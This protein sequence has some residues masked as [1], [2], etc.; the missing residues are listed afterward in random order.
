MKA[1]EA[2]SDLLSLGQPVIE[3]KEAA[4]RLGISSNRAAKLLRSTERAGLARQIRRGLWSLQSRI[5]PA[6]LALYLTAPYPAY[7]SVW[8]ALARHGIS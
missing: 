1:T 6:V 7:V 8:S 5:S 2:Y 3:T 4:A